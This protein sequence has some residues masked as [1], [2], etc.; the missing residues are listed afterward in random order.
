MMDVSITRVRFDNMRGSEKGDGRWTLPSPARV[1][2]PRAALIRARL[3]DVSITRMSRGAADASGDA[4]RAV[5]GDPRNHSRAR[6]WAAEA[7]D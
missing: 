5:S 2:T 3:M 4:A 1:S 7:R 6:E